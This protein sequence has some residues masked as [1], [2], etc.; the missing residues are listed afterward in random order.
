M[1]KFRISLIASLFLL[2][3]GCQSEDLGSQPTPVGSRSLVATIEGQD[4][5]DASRTAVD[6]SGNVTWI[7]TDELGVYGSVSENVKYSSTGNGSDVTFT[8]DLP[9]TEEAKWAYYPYD[10]DAS[11]DEGKLTIT[12]PDQ[13]TYTGNSNAPMLGKPSGNDKFSFKHLGG[14]IR[15][16]LGGGIPDD[17][18]RFVITSVGEN[19]PIAGQ[20]SFAIEG[21]NLTMSITN[22]GKQSISYDVSAIKDAKEF[23]HF[24][25][26][27]PVGDYAKLKVSFYKKSSETPVFTRSL[28]NLTVKRAEMICMPILDW[29]TGKQYT[30]SENTTDLTDL[31]EDGVTVTLKESDN[32]LE[33]TGLEE[34]KIP[35]AGQILWSQPTEELPYGFMG[36]VKEVTSSNGTVTITTET[37]GLDEVFDELLIEETVDLLP[38]TDSRSTST[39]IGVEKTYTIPIDIQDEGSAYGINGELNIASQLRSTI[40]INKEKSV[41]RMDFSLTFNPNL[42]AEMEVGASFNEDEEMIPFELK[43]FNFPP[44]SLGGGVFTINPALQFKLYIAPSGEISFKTDVDYNTTCVAGADYQDGQWKYGINEVNHNSQ[45]PWNMTSTIDMSGSLFLGAGVEFKGKIYNRNDLKI[46]IEPIIGVELSGELEIKSDDNNMQETLKDASLTTENVA[47]GKFGIDATVLAEQAEAS[48]NF[49]EKRWGEK[50]LYLFPMFENLAAQVKTMSLGSRSSMDPFEAT[51]TM[52]AVRELLFNY[53]LITTTIINEQH[54]EDSQSADYVDYKTTGNENPSQNFSMKFEYLDPMSSYRGYP[55]VNIPTLKKTIELSEKYVSFHSPSMDLRDKLIALYNAA[56]GE[57]W[58]NKD[59]WLSN[60]PIETWYGVSERDNEYSI[61]LSHNNLTGTFIINDP[62]IVEIH[63]DSNPGLTSVNVAECTSLKTLYYDKDVVTYLDVSSCNTLFTEGNWDINEVGTTGTYSVLTSLVARNLHS[64]TSF[65]NM[66]TNWELL[67]LSGC[68]NLESIGHSASEATHI[69]T[70][71]LS[72]CKKMTN[73]GIH[74]AN[75]NR[76]VDVLDI[77]GSNGIIYGRAEK[78]IYAQG[79]T[80]VKA[81]TV[82][83]NMDIVKCNVSGCENLEKIIVSGEYS[84]L[85]IEGCVN[86]SNLELYGD[87]YFSQDLSLYTNLD[88]LRCKINT[89]LNLSKNPKLKKLILIEGSVGELDISENNE[90]EEIILGNESEDSYADS[91]TFTKLTLPYN[92]SLKSIKT[93][94]ANLPAL[95]I[96]RLYALETISL[97]G[98]N[99]SDPMELDIT[100]NRALKKIT[101]SGK[102]NISALDAKG[103]L[104]LESISIS[105]QTPVTYNLDGCNGLKYINISNVNGTLDVRDCIN[106]STLDFSGENLT[107]L[108]I[109]GLNNI[110]YLNVSGTKLTSI[111]ISHCKSLETLYI[112]YTPLLSLDLS[113][114]SALKEFNCYENG[115]LSSLN[116][117]GCSSLKTFKCYQNGSLSTLILTECTSLKEWWCYENLQLEN[118]TLM[119]SAPLGSTIRLDFSNTKINCEIPDYLYDFKNLT[120][121]FKYDQRYTDYKTVW[122]SAN[123]KWV[124]TYTDNNYGWWFPGE[125]NSGKHER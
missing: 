11:L 125:P 97:Y 20:A 6:D 121:N 77:S 82:G 63:L 93:N 1:K 96:S 117:T 17:A 120:T 90:L 84:L 104:N 12:L 83:N 80:S 59:N 52:T 102:Y 91:V 47:S 111:D 28:S 115:S 86:L 46:Y 3:S 64:V 71:K 122:D 73:E 33:L 114:L 23:Q 67:D 31:S 94:K 30:L 45:S 14:L 44:I 112:G 10:K 27:L 53:V 88:T 109:S 110:Q 37:A 13:Y 9:E 92:S 78:E 81:V 22:D 113:G 36:K 16:T 106:L 2:L 107:K 95:D 101:M 65:H 40:H 34:N 39:T 26:P 54:E 124:V 100:K 79:N 87:N 69:G 55:A 15:F 57:N 50:Q 72:G 76:N 42:E 49:E 51:I 98:N 4:Y 60:Q 74:W 62:S 41:N 19:Q 58:T 118:L 89:S 35:E 7:T 29:N 61:N 70:L 99:I 105:S 21:D 68:E 66:D 32:T 25:V 56:G 108:D 38:T 119:S 85:N 48:F 75:Y 24:F 5:I 18:D 103:L 43:D 116:L 123:N 8:G